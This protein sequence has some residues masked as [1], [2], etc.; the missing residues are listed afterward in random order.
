MKRIRITPALSLL[1]GL[2]LLAGASSATAAQG[3]HRCEVDGRV[4]YSDLPCVP[5]PQAQPQADTGANAKSPATHPR[6]RTENGTDQER[7]VPDGA[8]GN[9]KR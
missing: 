2:A 1:A 7:R 9:P 5:P 6:Q 4:T 8:P 3:V